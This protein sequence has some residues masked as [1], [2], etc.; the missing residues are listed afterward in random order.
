MPLYRVNLNGKNYLIETDGVIEK[1]G[2]YTFRDV[3]AA[4]PEEAE[5]AAVQMLREDH[6]LRQI[7]KNAVDDPP[8]MHLEE[9]VEIEAPNPIQPG[10]IFYPEKTTNRWWQIWKRRHRPGA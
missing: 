1:Y 7:V 5:Y 8:T 10:F 2:F 3:T 9:L 4:N 6:G